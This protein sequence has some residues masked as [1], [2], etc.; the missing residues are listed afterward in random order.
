M[1]AGR[2]V[3]FDRQTLDRLYPGG[4][5]DYLDRFAASLDA[6]IA[7]GFIRPEDRGEILALA[8]ACYARQQ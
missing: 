7:A 5:A 2:T 3:P 8:E 4:P 6:A 1:L